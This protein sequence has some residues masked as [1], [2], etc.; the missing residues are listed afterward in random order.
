ME[1]LKNPNPEVK[2][3]KQDQAFLYSWWPMLASCLHKELAKE[4]PGMR[5]RGRR[6][7]TLS[8][9]LLIP[10]AILLAK[11]DLESDAQVMHRRLFLETMTS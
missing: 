8:S 4:M 1:I 5:T 10:G 6:V 9:D 11:P 3:S 2:T 7:M